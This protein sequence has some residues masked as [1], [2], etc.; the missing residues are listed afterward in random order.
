MAYCVNH[1]G[2][3]P[4]D[5]NDD[6]WTGWDFATLAEARIKYDEHPKDPST[7][8]VELDGPDVNEVRRVPG[9][10]ARRS[11]NDDWKHEIAMQAGMGL[12]IDAYNDEMGY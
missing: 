10:K 6:C 4:D 3:H 12:G 5:D 9:S 8:F 11:N 7:R 2:S 1:W